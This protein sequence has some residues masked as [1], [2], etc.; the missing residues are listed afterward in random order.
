M[1]MK[2]PEA[3]LMPRPERLQELQAMLEVEP[4][5]VGRPIAERAAWEA[6]R[7]RAGFRQ[8][9]ARAERELPL[10]T[11]NVTDELFLQFTREGDRTR[12]DRAYLGRMRRVSLFT[13]AECLEDAGRF[14]PAIEA[15]IAA[16][17]EERTWVMSAHDRDLVAF[18]GTVKI[19]IGVAMR[20][21]TLAT[22]DYL[23]GDRLSCATRAKIRH[24]VGQRTLEPLLHLMTTGHNATPGLGQLHCR[25]NYSIVVL[26]GLV[27][28]GLALLPSRQERALCVAAAEIYQRFF[29]EGY[30]G[31]GYCDE[32]LGYWN[33]GFGH[34]AYL[35]ETIRAATHVQLDWWQ[36]AKVQAIARFGA[37]IEIA[38]GAYPAF[39]DC[40]IQARPACWLMELAQRRVGLGTFNAQRCESDAEG[41]HLTALYA[42]STVAYERASSGT[43]SAPSAMPCRDWF[44]EASVLIARPAQT[45]GLGVALKGG[46]NDENHNHNDLGSYVV[47]VGGRALLL[48]A[49]LETY[50]ARTFSARRY[51]SRVLASY[52]HPVPLV[53]GHEQSAGRDRRA[54]VLETRF[55][56]ASDCIALDLRAAYDVPQLQ[57]LTRIWAFEAQP[58]TPHLISGSS[59]R[60]L[61]RNYV[62]KSM[63]RFLLLSMGKGTLGGC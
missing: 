2:T 23:L 42:L 37:R 1:Q 60:S 53:A 9:F 15:E 62:S 46:H 16:I 8:A 61:C 59:R 12:F 26:A 32:G 54:Q 38:D 31:D 52:G 35:A 57:A 48:D 25:N 19:D 51:E 5:G 3:A 33:Y 47:A 6:V 27:G 13:Q 10:P 56:D 34:Y 29:L 4:S 22:A 36:N 39:A 49:G 24:E 21:W 17:C 20:A 7:E 58:A 11:P 55:S 44:P 43:A 63:F 30:T 50:T 14:V 28:A 18:G 45:G 41:E 40:S